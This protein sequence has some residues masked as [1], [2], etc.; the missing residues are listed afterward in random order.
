MNILNLRIYPIK[1]T[2]MNCS[3]VVQLFRDFEQRFSKYY[4]SKCMPYEFNK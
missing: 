3:P 1:M 2:F 4:S